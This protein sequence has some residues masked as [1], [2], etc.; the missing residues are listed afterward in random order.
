MESERMLTSLVAID[1]AT[2][3]SVPGS[4]KALMARRA[5]KRLLLASSRSQR[6]SIQRSGSSSNFCRIGDWIG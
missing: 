6:T 4:F 5:M 3:A 2:S 1:W